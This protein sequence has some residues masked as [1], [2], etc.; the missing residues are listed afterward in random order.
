[1]DGL[2]YGSVL[3]IMDIHIMWIVNEITAVPASKVN[4]IISRDLLKQVI[5]SDS[6]VSDEAIKW[7]VIGN[8]IKGAK[9]K[10]ALASPPV[11]EVRRAIDLIAVLTTVQQD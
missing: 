10:K 7:T 4:D 1:M 3:S 9:D 5:I 6:G 2:C 8:I 11:Q